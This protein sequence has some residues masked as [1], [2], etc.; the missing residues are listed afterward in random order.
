MADDDDPTLAE[1]GEFT[2]I[3]RLIALVANPTRC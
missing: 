2:V 1:L 3:D